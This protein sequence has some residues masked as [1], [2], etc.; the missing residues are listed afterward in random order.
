MK[1]VSQY[2][3]VQFVMA[4]ILMAGVLFTGCSEGEKAG[5]TDEIES[6]FAVMTT[7]TVKGQLADYIEVNGD[8][9]SRTTVDTYPDTAGKLSSL[10][11][12]PGDSV[13]KDQVIAEVDPSRP[14]MTFAKSPVKAPISGTVI[15]TPMQVGSTVA[16][17]IPIVTI[18]R[19][20]DLEIQ[21]NVAERFIAKMSEGLDV[22]IQVDAYPDILFHGRIRELSPMVDSVSRTLG[23]KLDLIDAGT[24]LK[25]GMFAG[26]KIITEK[27]KGIVKIPVSCVVTRQD[28]YFVFVVKDDG[29]EG[30]HA[31]LRRIV[32]GMQIDNKL[33]VVEGLEPGETIVLRGQT[34][35][36]DGTRVKIV[37]TEPPLEAADVLYA[38][39][40]K[41]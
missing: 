40:A 12:G 27:K 35:L 17:S 32:P 39:P 13:R 5:I 25:A 28:E 36:E 19:M 29:T 6:V 11:V 1:K 20:D 37:E 23:M 33:E 7:E 9:V 2:P 38:P 16:P 26:I 31:E 18:A 14:G 8:V 21:T 22:V 34:L 24:K 15:R 3:A 41:E 10:F 4:G 30:A